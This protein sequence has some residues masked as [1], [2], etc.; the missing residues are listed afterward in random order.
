[1]NLLGS[2][3]PIR[4]RRPHPNHSRRANLPSRSARGRRARRTPCIACLWCPRTVTLP[5]DSE[6]APTVETD[7]HSS[8]L[9]TCQKRTIGLNARP[10][11][12]KGRVRAVRQL[13]EA[14]LPR[15]RPLS[16][17]RRADEAW[18]AAEHRER[19]V[20]ARRTAFKLLGGTTLV[21]TQ[22]FFHVPSTA[23]KI[24][25]FP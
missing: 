4:W 6:R 10:W 2:T 19:K 15:P 12:G 16:A 17:Y 9:A 3:W 22:M 7:P 21:L 8:R 14:P 18:R 11:K 13:S 23:L 25:R 1:M 20:K 24:F 5:M